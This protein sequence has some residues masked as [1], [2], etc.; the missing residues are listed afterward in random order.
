[1]LKILLDPVQALA[2]RHVPN[3]RSKHYF[4]FYIFVKNRFHFFERIKLS[5]LYAK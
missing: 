2:I 3:L 1:M 5:T 4:L